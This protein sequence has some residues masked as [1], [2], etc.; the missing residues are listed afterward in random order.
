MGRPRGGLRRRDQWTG[1]PVTLTTIEGKAFGDI[2]Q[3]PGLTPPKPNG[4]PAPATNGTKA[5]SETVTEFWAEVKRH[6]L[7]TDEGKRALQECG[8]DF[9]VALA[10][11]EG[12]GRGL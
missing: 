5:K 10:R 11:V 4:P 1:K 9:A 2:V 6:G 8:N 7:S 12:G 3:A